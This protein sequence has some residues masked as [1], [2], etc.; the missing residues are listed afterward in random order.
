MIELKNVTKIF[1]INKKEK[2][3]VVALDCINVSFEK[4][5]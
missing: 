3:N 5:D 1:D 2:I 4:K